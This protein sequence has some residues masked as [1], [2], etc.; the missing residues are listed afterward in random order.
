MI[1]GRRLPGLSFGFLGVKVTFDPLFL[2]LLAGIAVAGYLAEALVVI[3]ALMLHE[4]AH[5]GAARYFGY[6]AD[7]ISMQPFGGVANIGGDLADDAFA[8][9]FVALAGPANSLVLAGASLLAGNLLIFDQGLLQWFIDANLVL[10]FFNLFP[11]LPLDGG[12]VVRAVLSRRMGF[13]RSTR[14]LVSCGRG[15]AVVIAVLGLLGFVLGRYY[16]NL[17]F[18]AGF[19][20]LAAGREEE[21]AIYRHL[22]RL[23]KKKEALRKTGILEVTHLLVT[24]EAVLARV[25]EAL[26]PSKYNLVL[27]ELEGDGPGH[28]L[29]EDQVISALEDLGLRATVRDALGYR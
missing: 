10:G 29:T 5:I 16:L 26:H 23:L 12:R 4:T 9:A 3:G 11:C 17:F 27:V 22:L 1:A 14:L 24:G 7:S 18:L 25:V 2:L 8:E 20:Y 15:L 13:K 6:E 28:V 21:G 19:L